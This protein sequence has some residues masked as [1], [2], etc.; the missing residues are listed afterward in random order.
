MRLARVT[1]IGVRGLADATYEFTAQGA[2]RPGDVVFTGPSGA[3]KTRTLDAIAAAKEAIAPYGLPTR[4]AAWAPDGGGVATIELTVRVDDAEM[5]RL[6]T[7]DVD[8]RAVVRLASAAVKVDAH[9]ALRAL[10]HAYGHDGAIGK[11]ELFGA[12][13]RLAALPPFAGLSVIEQR[14]QRCAR[15]PSKYGFVPR[16][17]RDV[18]PASEG[19]RAL[20]A[21]IAAL[22]PTVRFTPEVPRRLGMPR[23]LTSKDG[24]P[25]ELRELADSEK[26]AVIFAATATAFGLDRS[27]LLIDRPDRFVAPAAL[28]AFVAGLRTLGVDN[29]L[30]LTSSS[31]DLAAAAAPAVAFTLRR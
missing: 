12:D 5:D 27:V 1:F 17:L 6:Q 15:D 26:D 24:A 13:R 9:P 18:D 19:A 28:P 3:G 4:G 11:V 23:C 30:V 21:R 29:Q 25:V 2:R 14:P 22:S 16:F 20:A 10:F 7:S 31:P 8:L